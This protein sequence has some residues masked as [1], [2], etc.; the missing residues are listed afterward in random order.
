[1]R[2]AF[3]NL[4]RCILAKMTKKS[5]DDYFLIKS[6]YRSS[7]NMNY[8][9]YGSLS[10]VALAPKIL[11]PKKSPILIFC[12]QFSNIEAKLWFHL[13]TDTE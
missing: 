13:Y 10:G 7:S 1:M 9:K 6:I 8:K 3:P 4:L 12:R 2:V 5:T 11:E